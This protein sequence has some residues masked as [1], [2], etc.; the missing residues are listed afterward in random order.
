M[1]KKPLSDNEIDDRLKAARAVLGEEHGATVPGETALA[2][3]RKALELLS[4][5]LIMAGL[6]RPDP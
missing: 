3:A 2:A 6:K 4:L 1:S 5:G